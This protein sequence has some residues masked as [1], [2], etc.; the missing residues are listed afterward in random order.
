MRKSPYKKSK[1]NMSS[2]VCECSICLNDI[3]NQT[4]KVTMA[5]SHAFHFRCISN[6][7]I[8]QNDNDQSESCPYCRREA[9]EDEALPKIEEVESEDE[10]S[11]SED[12]EEDSDDE[13]EEEEEEE[14]DDTTL[15]E[16]ASDLHRNLVRLEEYKKY[17]QENIAMGV[18]QYPPQ[19][20]HAVVNRIIAYQAEAEEKIKKIIDDEFTKIWRHDT[21]STS[22]LRITIPPATPTPTPISEEEVAVWR[23]KVDALWPALPKRCNM[24]NPEDEQW[25]D[26]PWI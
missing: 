2:F 19:D 25:V 20:Y 21:A 7:F 8:E 14:A 24:M 1:N 10:D 4:G 22:S 26:E 13:E 18:E 12:E 6:W 16:F 5:C 11:E 9:S 17:T 23:S 3:T 15:I